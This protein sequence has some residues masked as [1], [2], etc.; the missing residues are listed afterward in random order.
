MA[1]KVKLIYLLDSKCGKPVLKFCA[2]FEISEL[3]FTGILSSLNS[4]PF[5]QQYKHDGCGNFLS[6]CNSLQ[7]C[8]MM[9][10]DV[11]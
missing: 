8:E 5:L 9:L 1:M 2:N 3:I 4:V 6:R 11:S 7:N 10:K